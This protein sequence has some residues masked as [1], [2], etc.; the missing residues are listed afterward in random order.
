MPILLNRIRRLVLFAV[1][2]VAWF[3]VGVIRPSEALG[4]QKKTVL[5]LYGDPL[6][7]PADRM[8]EQGLT[9][10]LSS[11]HGRDLEVFSEYLDL[12]RFPE[13]QY[14]GD[15]A[16]YLRA[17]YGTRKPDVLIALANTTLQFVLDHRDE[18]FPGVPIV[19]ADVD[20]REVEGRQMPPNVAGLWMAWDYQRTLEL[21]LQ[22]Q[23]EIREV[24]CVSGTGAEEQPWNDEA[25][26]VLQRFASQVRTRWLDKLPLQ[27]VLDEVARLPLDSVVLYIPMQRD[28]AGQAVSPFEV[29]RQLADASRVPVY[30]LSRPQLQ[31]GIIGGALLDFSEIGNKTATLALRVL[32]GEKLP[33]ISA[34]DIATYP[35]LINWQ[36]LKK[37]HVSQSRIPAEA[38]VVYR[39]PSL[40]EQH[41]RLILATAA[42]LLLQSVL[43]AGLIFQ[44]SRR[45]RAELSLRESE[46]Q[47]GLAASA[48]ELG[49]WTWDILRDRIWISDKGRALFGIAP[50][51]RVDKAALSARV[52]PEDRAA[53]DAAIRHALETPGEYAMEYRV[54]HSDGQMRWIAARG[55]VEFGDGKPLRMRGVS[56]DITE[57]RQAELEA[58]RQRTDLAHASRLAIVGE[59]TASIAHEI[60]QPLG[61]ILS[62]AETAEILLQSKQPHLEEIQHILADIRKDDLRASEV[63]RRMRELLRK[64]ELEF[65]L[66]DLN[67]VASN[68][69]RFVDGETHRRGVEI[70]KQFAD[71]LPVVR[72]DVIHL[73]QVLLNL[74]LNGMEAMSES[75]KSNRRLTI[76]TAYDGKGNIEVAVEDSGPGIPSERLPRLFDSFF[77]TKTHGMGLGLSIVRSIVEAHGGRIWAENNASGGACFRFTLPVNGKE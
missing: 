50:E 14:G 31:Q 23:P 65:K 34:P 77:T 61:A 59:L 49:M 20:H 2:Y 73:Q 63:I 3:N 51:T 56:L 70:E 52:H 10:A 54:V 28:G 44:G 13:A 15:I 46:Q 58:A 68:V 64:R 39:E 27:A 24:V 43:I 38:T 21:A 75:S 35:L 71:T 67:V 57:R 37:W 18:L 30:G 4:I 12:E 69:L 11:A 9:A 25:S 22:L 62:N 32:A 55:R 72:G 48:A 19:F 53:R 47:M 41:R 60:N 1:F 42:T 29:A 45:K 26:K 33:L 17:R 40:W 16:R 5:V 6:S 74:I 66:I 8:T 76:R 36:A 7:T